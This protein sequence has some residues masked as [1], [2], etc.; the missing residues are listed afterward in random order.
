VVVATEILKAVAV[1]VAV[2]V[3]VAVAV[4]VAVS[5]AVAVAVAVDVSVAV[6]VAVAVAVSV[7]VAVEVKVSTTVTVGIVVFANFSRIDEGIMVELAALAIMAETLVD[8][9]PLS[10]ESSLCI[11]AKQDGHPTETIVGTM[12]EA[13]EVATIGQAD[14]EVIDVTPQTISPETEEYIV[15]FMQAI[16][17]A[18]DKIL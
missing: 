15:G 3:S 18:L 16:L 7:A 4:A 13:L 12:A 9:N 17:V 10:I 11:P 5:V 14:S 1:A 6:A 2:A 8:K